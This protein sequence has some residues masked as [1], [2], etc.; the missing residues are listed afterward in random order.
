MAKHPLV[1]AVVIAVTLLVIS[2]TSDATSTLKIEVSDWNWNPNTITLTQGEA[3]T[4]EITNTGL[5]P[6]GIWVPELGINEG[7]RAGK[8]IYVELTPREKGEF[9]IRCSDP[10][11]GTGEQHVGMMATLIIT[12]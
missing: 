8:T 2:C 12:E 1:S 7:V 6:H 3:V 9:M 5:M 4:L 10:T 11:C